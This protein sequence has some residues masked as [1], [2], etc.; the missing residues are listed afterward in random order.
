M[1]T[2][3]GMTCRDG[4]LLIRDRGNRGFGKVVPLAGL[5]VDDRRSTV[6]C[7]SAVEATASLTGH[8]RLVLGGQYSV[9]EPLAPSRISLPQRRG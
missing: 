3:P 5:A 8:G 1:A 6:P 7:S 4:T 2:T 9:G